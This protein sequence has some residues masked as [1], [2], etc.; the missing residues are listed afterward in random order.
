MPGKDENSFI[1][2]KPENAVAAFKEVM[3]FGGKKYVIDWK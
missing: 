1:K 2:L 3:K